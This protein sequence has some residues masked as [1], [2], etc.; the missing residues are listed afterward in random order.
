MEDDVNK[1]S[2][3]LNIQYKDGAIQVIPVDKKI[4]FGTNPSNTIKASDHKLSENHANIRLINDVLSLQVMSKDKDTFLNGKKLASGKMFILYSK[5]R[6]LMGD[7]SVSI[8]I[9]DIDAMDIPLNGPDS[10]SSEGQDLQEGLD[11]DDLNEN[12]E[13]GSL[14]KESTE[15]KLNVTTLIKLNKEEKQENIL[16]DINPQDDES[17]SGIDDPPLVKQKI[18]FITK[19]KNVFNK[20]HAL[21]TNTKKEKKRKV[22]FDDRSLPG[23]ILR[24]YCVIT[25]IAFSYAIVVHLFPLLDLQNVPIDLAKMFFLTLKEYSLNF[26][27]LSSALI[28]LETTI[29]N[30]YTQDAGPFYLLIDVYIIFFVIDFI[31]HI[32]FGVSLP[33][34][35]S[36][37]KSQNSILINRIQG[38]LRSA[39]GNIFGI[40]LILDL[41]ILAKKRTIKEILTGSHLT[42]DKTVFKIL[43]TIFIFPLIIISSLWMHLLFLDTSSAIITSDENV[44]QQNQITTS[45]PIK[46]LFFNSHIKNQNIEKFVFIPA[47]NKMFILDSNL[48]S[49][50]ELTTDTSLDF[51]EISSLFQVGNPLFFIQYPEFQNIESKPDGIAQIDFAKLLQHSILLHLSPEVLLNHI[52][53]FGPFVSGYILAQRKFLE[54]LATSTLLDFKY[55]FLYDKTDTSAYLKYSPVN[56]FGKKSFEFVYPMI[57]IKTTGIKISYSK[58]NLQFKDDVLKMILGNF[59]Y[60]GSIKKLDSPTSSPFFVLDTFSKISKN[61]EI[62]E[63]TRFALQDFLLNLIPTLEKITDKEVKEEVIKIISNIVKTMSTHPQKDLF[64]QILQSFDQLK[65]TLENQQEPSLSNTESTDEN[66]KSEV[67]PEQ[68]KE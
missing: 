60:R 22:V 23:P 37:V 54:Q 20:S 31:S 7:L 29:S 61:E 45:S 16:D 24:L 3:F 6:I 50:L 14:K 44:L 21:S 38:M 25:G 63:D 28:E 34:F 65:I 9:K 11:N 12:Q 33:L 13:M 10:L 27:P 64:L 49:Y 32:I 4:T 58:K 17:H 39:L 66:T 26:A 48:S 56:N 2:Y 46:S 5:D 1:S 51:Y 62:D 8:E 43:A 41:P 42:V 47:I 53:E 19:I 35:L 57:P 68:N 52:L 59:T 40:I 15:T 30:F 55:T 36:G 18:S 67:L